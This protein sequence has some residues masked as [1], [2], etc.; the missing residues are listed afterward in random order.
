VPRAAEAVH[1]VQSDVTYVVLCT[2]AKEIPAAN[3]ERCCNLLGLSAGRHC[4]V[5]RNVLR[6]WSCGH[7]CQC[8]VG[9]NHSFID[10]ENTRQ[11]TYHQV[12]NKWRKHLE[13]QRNLYISCIVVWDQVTHGA[14]H[15]TSQ[16]LIL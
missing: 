2:F 15:W 3:V 10:V 14:G 16:Q 7:V 1:V 12:L 6:V 11:G 8:I 13:D 9:F 5:L 4:H